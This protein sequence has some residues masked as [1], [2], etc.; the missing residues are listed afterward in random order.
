V[1]QCRVKSKM[2]DQFAALKKYWRLCAVTFV[3]WFIIDL[4]GL[5]RTLPTVFGAIN[6]L[7][8][9]LV[10]P[11]FLDIFARKFLSDKKYLASNICSTI[12]AAISEILNLVPGNP[13]AQGLPFFLMMQVLTL[14]KLEKAVAAEAVALRLVD[15]LKHQK[16]I[17][18]MR[19][20]YATVLLG[21]ALMQQGR[22]EEAEKETREAID[23]FAGQKDVKPIT[24]AASLS[25]L[26]ATLSREGRTKPAIEIGKKALHIAENTSQE[27]N[28]VVIFG[29]ILNNL[30]IA[31]NYAGQS[32]RALELYQ[33]SLK[34]K[35]HLLGDKCRE[36]VIGFNNVGIVLTEQKEYAKEIKEHFPPKCL[37]FENLNLDSE[38]TSRSPI[39]TPN[40]HIPEE[41]LKIE[42][43]KTSLTLT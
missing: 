19:L 28:E 15:Y 33:R 43:S 37:I 16:N 31:Y 42:K 1:D 29:M 24:V 12:A 39:Q 22:F 25:D 36:A 5:L 26:C 10:L 32:D 17:N 27:G 35:L 18:Q 3:A 13:Y 38:N 34:I 9:I 7:A 41:T 4:N 40:I 2:T 8:L 23:I 20:A 30:A 14:N 21:N 11:A 6:L